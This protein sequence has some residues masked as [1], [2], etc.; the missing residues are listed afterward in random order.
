[1]PSIE[2]FCPNTLGLI[3]PNVIKARS[4]LPIGAAAYKT[5]LEEGKEI[6]KQIDGLV[7]LL[8]LLS[9]SILLRT[10]EHETMIATVGSYGVKVDNENVK[11]IQEWLMPKI[12]RKEIACE[13]AHEYGL[14]GN[15]GELKTFDVLNEHFFWSHMRK[16]VGNGGGKDT[17]STKDHSIKQ[18]F[19]NI[20]KFI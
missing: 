1:M 14:I 20:L 10:F 12:V 4:T 16:D 11:A 19:C 15:F 13:E 17:W 6:Q 5:N 7:G 2:E 3:N 18:R 8:K 9:K